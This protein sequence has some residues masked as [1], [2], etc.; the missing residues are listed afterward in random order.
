VFWIL[1]MFFWIFPWRQIVFCR[2][3]GT[4]CQVHL[5]RLDVEYE[6][7]MVGGERGIW[8]NLFGNLWNKLW[9]DVRSWNTWYSYMLRSLWP[10]LLSVLIWYIYF[11][12]FSPS[13][14]VFSLC[15]NIYI[16]IWWNPPLL[17]H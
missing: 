8:W 1:Y 12:K 9:M 2:R 6:V 17:N 14:Y 10:M 13:P 11:M 5:Q 4:L 16:Y 7:W 15:S 3:F